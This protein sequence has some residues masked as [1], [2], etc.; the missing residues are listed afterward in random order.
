MFTST[1]TLLSRLRYHF[2]RELL[3]NQKG[4]MRV[5]GCVGECPF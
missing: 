2:G 3:R 1:H 4:K 5:V